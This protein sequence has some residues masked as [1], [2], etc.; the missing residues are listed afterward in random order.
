MKTRVRL[1]PIRAILIPG[2][3]GSS[4]TSPGA[5]AGII[6]NFWYRL[7]LMVRIMFRAILSINEFERSLH[8]S[9]CIFVGEHARNNSFFFLAAESFYD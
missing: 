2:H 3:R 5:L 1:S 7:W 8:P 6:P 4:F 9:L